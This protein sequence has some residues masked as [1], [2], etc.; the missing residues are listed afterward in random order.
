MED[1]GAATDA[2]S[3]LLEILVEILVA[4]PAHQ[5]VGGGDGGV[6]TLL[7]IL[8]LKLLRLLLRRGLLVSTLLEILANCR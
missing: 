5:Q 8:E 3:T 1:R 7:E 6:S 4:W 2:V